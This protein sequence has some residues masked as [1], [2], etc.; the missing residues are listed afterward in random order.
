[1]ELK[2]ANKRINIGLMMK[3]LMPELRGKADGK[4]INKR[5]L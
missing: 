4:I 1:M 2:S 3:A 5:K